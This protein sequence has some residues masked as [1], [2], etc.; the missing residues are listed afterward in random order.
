MRLWPRKSVAL[1][2]VRRPR[3]LLRRSSLKA[4]L[5]FAAGLSPYFSP[6]LA[7]A[8]EVR[9]RSRTLGE[10][11]M[12]RAPGSE[13]LLLSRRRLVQYVDLGVFELLPPRDRG[14]FHRDPKDGQLRLVSSMRLRHDFGSYMDGHPDGSAT[15]LEAQ[16]GRQI[17]LLYAYLEGKQIAKWVDFR[18]GRQFEM[19]GLDW[20]AFDGGWLR[21]RTPAHLAVET[22]GG[23]E[24]NA[25]DFLGY[26][27]YEG[28]G[29][30][31]RAADKAIS[32]MFGVA[33]ALDDLRRVD[34]R[35]AYRRSMSPAGLNTQL[36]ED[37]GGGAFESRVDQEFVSATTSLHLLKGR[38]TP[39]S[40]VRANLGTSRIDDINIG[41]QWA[42]AQRHLLRASYLRTIPSFDLDSIFNVFSLRPFEE[43]RLLYQVRPGGRWTVGARGQLRIFH[44]QDTASLDLAPDSEIEHG[45]GGG[46][47]AHWRNHRFALR[48]DAFGLDGEGGLRAGGSIDGRIGLLND[49]LFLDGRSYVL[50]FDRDEAEDSTRRR[51]YSLAF[52]AGLHF[53][54][55]RGIHLEVVGE[56][57]SSSYFAHALR[58]F[59][60]LHVEWSFRGGGY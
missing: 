49:R 13:D 2:F 43:S 14:E 31:G 24:V 40:A 46:A 37:E 58:L 19:S 22:F 56:E 16:D 5:A 51:G 59:G 8:T 55:W 25:S 47:F 10:A 18:I 23:F 39:F 7:M 11:Y 20:Y 15:L 41:L 17:D 50:H 30:W 45:Y 60:V 6:D 35:V 4:Y 29:T 26:P 3:S 38:L 36:V 42:F 1:R 57:M 12:L 9:V 27:S 48:L 21:V 33:V 28:D 34:A 52:Q 32:P 54:V 53:R 44:Q